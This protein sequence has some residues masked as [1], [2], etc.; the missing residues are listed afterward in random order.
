MDVN[1]MIIPSHSKQ[2][3]QH[4]LQVGFLTKYFDIMEDKQLL[5]S[6]IRNCLPA[7]EG[8]GS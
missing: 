4:P 3:F 1:E 5:S 2:G 6:I 7:G 8:L